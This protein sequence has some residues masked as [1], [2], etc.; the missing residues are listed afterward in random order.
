MQCSTTSLPL[1][2][3]LLLL[4]L[5]PSTSS[6]PSSPLS[7][8]SDQEAIRRSLAVLQSRLVTYVDSHFPKASRQDQERIL[9][10]LVS[11]AQREIQN[12]LRREDRDKEDLLARMLK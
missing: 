1:L 5:L 6:R 3:L 11:K 7:R 9:K 12:S 10:L 2:S 4:V 8:S